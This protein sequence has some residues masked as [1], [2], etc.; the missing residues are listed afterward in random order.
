M[1]L[2]RTLLFQAARRLAADPRV[3]AKAAEVVETEIKP[4]ARAAAAKA[5]PRIEETRADLRRIAAETDP[6]TQPARFA[7]RAA[8]RIVE[9]VKGVGVKSEDAK[10]PKNPP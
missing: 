8:R 7:R 6:R 2:L 4:R 10:D 5:K 3:R 9:G 1:A